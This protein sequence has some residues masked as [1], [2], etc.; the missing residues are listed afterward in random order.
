MNIVQKRNKNIDDN[1]PDLVI[2]KVLNGHLFPCEMN[3]KIFQL[4]QK[5]DKSVTNHVKKEVEFEDLKAKKA[6][7]K[8]V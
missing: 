2:N 3:K 4:E 6:R 8:S 1:N 5:N 7:A